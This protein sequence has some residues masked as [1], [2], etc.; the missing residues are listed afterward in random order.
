V[1]GKG[2]LKITVVPDFL[3][4]SRSFELKPLVNT[5]KANMKLSLY[6]AFVLCMASVISGT[7]ALL[8]ECEYDWYVTRSLHQS[9][10]F[11]V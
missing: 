5:S 9:V 6:S 8:D 1:N 2:N 10:A 3:I 4:K 7:D 11:T